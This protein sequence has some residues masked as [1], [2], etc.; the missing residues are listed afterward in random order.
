[1][2]NSASRRLRTSLPSANSLHAWRE[3][4]TT[5]M[6][7]VNTHLWEINSPTAADLVIENV[8]FSPLTVASGENIS[9]SFNVRNVGQAGVAATKAWLRLSTDDR[10]TRHDV[11]LLPLDV[12]IPELP[13]GL[14]YTFTGDFRVPPG[15]S[16]DDYY[17]GVFADADDRAGQQNTLN[18]A[19]LS[20]NVLTA[21][22]LT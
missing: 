19:G 22:L 21:E 15:T 1:M 5:A 13:A 6:G 11:G 20:P 16:Q 17:V 8:T 4:Y 18:D 14:A 2:E 12:E 10:L 7:V 9:V 3:R